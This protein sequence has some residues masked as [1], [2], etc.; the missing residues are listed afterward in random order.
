MLFKPTQ[1]HRLLADFLFQPVRTKQITLKLQRVRVRLIEKS[2]S[3]LEF[4]KL[5]ERSGQVV[6]ERF[7]INR[8]KTLL[9]DRFKPKLGCVEST[10]IVRKLTQP[11]ARERLGLCGDRADFLWQLLKRFVRRTDA[12]V[13]IVLDRLAMPVARFRKHIRPFTFQ[14]GLLALEVH[15]PRFPEEWLLQ[16]WCVGG[17]CEATML[18]SPRLLNRLLVDQ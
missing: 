5:L 2:D 14:G 9:I 16:K 6:S 18:D 3:F 4:A 13:G 10:Q 7:D 1:G 12:L 11:K 8:L 17:H 15:R